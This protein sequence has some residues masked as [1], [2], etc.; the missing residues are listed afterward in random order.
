[1][2][3]RRDPIYLE[4]DVW[5]ELRLIAKAQTGEGN[6]VTADQVANDLLR[7]TLTERWPQLLEH[8]KQVAKMERQLIK[9]LGEGK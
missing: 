2:S 3:I 8:Q 7:V 6:I 9:Q 1:M 4:Y 5:R